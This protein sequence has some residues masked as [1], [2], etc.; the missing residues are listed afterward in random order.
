MNCIFCEIVKGQANCHKIWED[1]KHIAILSIFPNTTGFSVVMPKKHYP[2]Y[3]F[4]LENDVLIDLMLASKC[5]ALKLDKAFDDVGRTGMILEGF[6]VNHL[7]AKLVPMHGTEKQDWRQIKSNVDKFF[8]QYEGFISSHDH[9][10][11]S[12]ENLRK[13]ADLIRGVN[14]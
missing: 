14:F 1:D 6:G 9:K 5:V 12:D 10:L 8:Y 2:S 4:E 3:A 11:Q 7:H 13:V